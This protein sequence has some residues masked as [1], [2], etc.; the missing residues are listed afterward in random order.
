MSRLGGFSAVVKNLRKQCIELLTEIDA[1]LDFEDEMPPIDIHFIRATIHAML[2]DVERELETANYDKLLQSGL[3]RAIVTE[4]AGT[5]RDVV[6]ASIA[7]EGIPVTLLDTAGIRETDDV[8]ER[9]ANTTIP[10]PTST[11]QLVNNFKQRGLD[12]SDLVALSVAHTIGMARCV[13]FKSR[14]YSQTRKPDLT[15][16][17]IYSNELKSVCPQSEGDNVVSPLDYAFFKLILGGRG[18]LSSDEALLTGNVDSVANMVKAYA[19]NEGLFFNHFARSV[20]EM[21]SIS[22]LLGLSGEIRKH[23]RSVN[24]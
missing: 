5:T 21:G 10:A 19:A 8:V 24:S 3:Q 2:H 7:D 4:I 13:T 6:E 14:L 12:E 15:L 18:L 9:I 1:R 16:E 22:P 20:I 17:R 11:I 23:C